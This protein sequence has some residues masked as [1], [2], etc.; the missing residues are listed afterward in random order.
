MSEEFEIIN[1]IP[2]GS[3]ISPVLFNVMINNIFMNL[4][5]RVGSA[6][7]ADDG[8]IWVRGRDPICVISKIKEAMGKVEQWSYNWGFKLSPSK[9]CHMLFIRKKGIDKHNLKLYGH[10]HESG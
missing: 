2:Q 5:R 8:A 3:V 9:S 7:Y 1:G 4:D 6:L 10:C